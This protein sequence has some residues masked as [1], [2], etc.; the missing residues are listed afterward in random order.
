MKNFKDFP[1]ISK[2]TAYWKKMKTSVFER[3]ILLGLPV[4][5]GSVGILFSERR[6]ADTRREYGRSPDPG[7][8]GFHYAS[9]IS[10]AFQTACGSE[11]Q[12]PL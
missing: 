10:F 11:P 3:T 2:K 8:S 9:P 5:H 4:R 6:H 12:W 1:M 7:W